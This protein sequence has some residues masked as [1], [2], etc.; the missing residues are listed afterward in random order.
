MGEVT[1]VIAD[2]EEV[3]RADLRRKLAALWP[4]L[5]I[6]GEAA[7]GLEAARLIAAEKPDVV[8]LDIRMPGLTGIEVA[9]R[10]GRGCRVV[11]VTAYD[12]Y[13]VDAF[14][15]E[16]VDYLLK[17]ISEPRL[18]KTVE[19]LKAQLALREPPPAQLASLVER[20]VNALDV[21][22]PPSSLR[23]IKASHRDGVRIVPVEEVCYFQA[24][25][26]YTAAVTAEGELLI[27]KTI[28][29]L[30]GELDPERFWQ[31]HRGTVVNAGCVAGTTRFLTGRLSLRLRN[32]PETLMVG[33]AFAHRFKQM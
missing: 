13:A 3:L 15:K 1:A 5:L 19:R 2:D 24:K 17:P 11:F 4:E 22:R 29:D 23:W 27:K 18:R 33:R 10:I 32:R 20:L 8:F 12:Q 25:D 26:K 31:I 7:N 9:G 16:A 28:R 21:Q 14:E 30:V 6:C